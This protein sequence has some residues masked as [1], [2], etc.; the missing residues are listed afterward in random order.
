ENF[1]DLVL[2]DP[3]VT[4]TATR[5]ATATRTPTRTAT[6]SPSPTPVQTIDISAALPIDCGEVAV[7]NTAGA[8]DNVNWY[9][10]APGWPENGPENVYRFTAPGGVTVDALLGGL[11]EDLDLFVLTGVSPSTCIAAGDTSVSLPDLA[12]GDYYLVIDGFDGASGPY[13]LNVWCPLDP[14]PQASPTPTA[15]VTP[16]PRL[17]RLYLPLV[18][19]RP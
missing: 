12:A 16:Q 7:G 8:A 19:A 18:S 11:S 13:R 3:F 1:G 14:S 5:T 9:A 6:P 2:L 17:L 10:C 15:T 4:P